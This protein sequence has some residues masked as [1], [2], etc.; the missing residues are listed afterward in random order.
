MLRVRAVLR[1]SK[2]FLSGSVASKLERTVVPPEGVHLPP[3]L[4]QVTFFP[5]G[6][7]ASKSF[8]DTVLDRT[9]KYIQRGVNECCIT[10]IV[11]EGVHPSKESADVEKEE[12][13]MAA[14]NPKARAF[15]M[16]HAT[17]GTLYKPATQEQM[18]KE[19]GIACPPPSG[20][21]LQDAYFK[22]LLACKVGS[23]LVNGDIISTSTFQGTVADANKGRE[24]KCIATIL[25]QFTASFNDR[26][27][28]LWG[29]HHV[30][31]LK[32]TLIQ[33]HS[34][35]EVSPEEGLEPLHY[36]WT[37]KDFRQYFGNSAL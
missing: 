23:F 35:V 27:L 33:S 36:G 7:V 8:F 16:E 22:P 19:Y 30:P 1:L 26:L 32:E 31:R 10:K 11:V 13:A 20:L 3:R 9:V 17:A 24:E 28:V 25:E 21:V 6:H 37:E 5:M 29:H 34:F 4:Q 14:A 2:S 15:L 12:W 18:C